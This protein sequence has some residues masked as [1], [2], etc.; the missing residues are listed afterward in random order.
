MTKRNWA[1]ILCGLALGLA[2]SVLAQNSNSGDIRGTVTD[3]SGAV[4]PSATVTVTDT[5]T[6]VVNKYLTNNDGLYDTNSIL[7]GTY[8]VEFSKGG[9]ESYKR[10]GIPLEVG[11]I[12]VDAQLKVGATTAVVEV[13]ASEIP[14]LKTE[15]AQVS[16]TLTTNE[17][18]N[19]PNSNP[20]NGYTEFLKLLPGATGVTS[21]NNNGGGGNN[22]DPQFDQAINGTMPYFSSYL[23]DGGSIWLP[24]SANTDQGISESVSELNVIGTDAPS[25][26]GGGGSVFN[27]ILKSGSETF[28][29]S[30]YD[31]IQNNK[32]NA[33]N[34]FQG[35]PNGHER[36]NYFGGAIGGPIIKNKMFFYYNYQQL[37]NPNT[38]FSTTTEPTPAMLAGCFNPT[39]FGNYLKLDAAHG[40]T[41]LTYG[42]EADIAQCQ[43]AD[44]TNYLTDLVI[45]TAD[46]DP[47]AKNI[48][49]DYFLAGQQGNSTLSS[50]YTYLA[51][52]NGDLAKQIGRLDYNI[53]PTNRI[54]FSIIER[55]TPVVVSAGSPNCPVNCGDDSSDGGNG[56]LSD[57]WSIRPNLINEARFS[58]NREAD[59]FAQ[60]SLN[61]GVIA[62]IG[63]QFSTADVLPSLNIGGTG[64]NGTISPNTEA[65]FIQNSFLAADSLTW[66]KGKNILHFGGEVLMEQDDSTPW[67]GINGATLGFSGQFTTSNPAFESGYADFLLGDVQSW[68]TNTTP[69]HYM[70][71]NNPSFYA[72]DD[73]KLRPNLTV[74][75]GVRAEIHG[76]SWEKYNHAGGFDPS[77]ADPL[78]SSFVSGESTYPINPLGSIWFAGLNGER[79]KS[80]ANKTAVMPR[81]GFAW[82]PTNKWVVRG[83]VGQYAS[84]WSEDTVGGPMGFGSGAVGSASVSTSSTVP[85]VQLSGSGSNLPIIKGAQATTPSA[86][87]TPATPQGSGGSIPYTPYELPIQNGWQWMGGVQYRLPGNIVAEGQYVGSHWENMMFLAD[88]NQLSAANL[89]FVDPGGIDANG[90]NSKRPYPQ[91][92][93]IG[94]GSGGSRT[95]SY[96]G[97]SNYEA[98]SFLIH[99]TISH[100]LALSA[101]YTWSV[102]KDDMDD[103]GWGE[104]F[105]D[106]YYQDAYNPAANYAKSNL[107]RPNVLKGVVLYRVPLGKGH[108]YLS[109]DIGD[110]VLGGWEASGDYIA[111]S[112]TPITV[113]MNDP[114]NNGS[115]GSSDGNGESAWYPNLTGNPGSGG[116]I[117]SWFNQQAYVSPALDTFGTNPR[118]SLFGPDMVWFDFSLAKSFSMPG[119]ERGKLQIRMDANNI[120]NHPAFAGPKTVLNPSA[121]ITTGNP[122]P[123]PDASVGRITG[124]DGGG[125]V[126]QLSARFS[127]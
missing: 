118:N 85:E 124:T 46:F 10:S 111:E 18:T 72:Q 29:G 56:Q 64:G 39:L 12:T 21:G 5:D 4:V 109:S 16:T 2:S 70:R 99:N 32:F 108:Q 41:A 27:V 87:I 13:N 103:S 116:N 94:V 112:G 81:L 92:S 26:Y 119:W 80:N 105:G 77:L 68:N 127:F 59:Y 90:Y 47:V 104:Q 101:A 6:G 95:G 84:L 40:G 71:A 100:G 44:P 76:G 83:G 25:Q 15:D 91:F 74:N 120:F 123:T 67:G 55:Y 51:P 31:Y 49:N 36:Y 3:T 20:S 38:S 96:N 33:R 98:V 28:H 52:G 34:Y 11:I 102:M 117:H 35:G 75:I 9:F 58:F 54:D 121:L 107:N 69:K 61:V 17:L 43:T 88:D 82:Q 115:L 106:S 110:A 22:S 24:H 1:V 73:I 126:I 86:Y 30:A 93:G 79:T 78:G 19:L 14:L 60:A 53:T 62:K 122:N 63:L 37:K 113:T 65:L 42:T 125:R 23:V 7:P 114:A 97:I 45:P 8:T 48:Q 57:V 50:N 89:G 66:I